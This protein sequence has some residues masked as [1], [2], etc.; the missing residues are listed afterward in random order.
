MF[1]GQCATWINPRGVQG[2][3]EL[4]QHAAKQKNLQKNNGSDK[5]PS[6]RERQI[7]VRRGHYYQ[8]A[9]HHQQH[10]RR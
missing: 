10:H 6:G 8:D 4:T 5:S 1:A 3:P 2:K 9:E 7:N